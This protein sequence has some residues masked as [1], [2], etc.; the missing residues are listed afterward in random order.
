MRSRSRVTA[1]ITVTNGESEL[2][3]TTIDALPPSANARKK[4]MLPIAARMPVENAQAIP[5]RRRR[6][7]S[8]RGERSTNGTSGSRPKVKKIWFVLAST[9]PDATLDVAPQAPYSRI[10][11]RE[12]A[13]QDGIP[14]MV[15]GCL[16]AVTRDCMLE[17]SE[18]VS[19]KLSWLREHNR[20]RGFPKR[21]P[22]R[23]C[24]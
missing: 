2:A 7:E 20:V 11:K 19:D 1:R 9:L 13:S 16:C 22:G 3:G 12:K 4:A 23:D 14:R 17:T 10:V 21:S 24:N 15:R 6:L 5:A 18:G 8:M